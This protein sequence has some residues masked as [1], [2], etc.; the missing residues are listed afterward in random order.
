MPPPMIKSTRLAAD[1]GS[2]AGALQLVTDADGDPIAAWS[3][4]QVTVD[5]Q[6][7]TPAQAG[8]TLTS[9][10]H[11]AFDPRGLALYQRLDT[12]RSASVSVTYTASDGTLTSNPATITFGVAGRDDAPVLQVAPASGLEDTAIPLDI[13]ASAIDASLLTGESVPEEVGP[14][15]AVTGATVNAGG[16]L[17]VRATR[18]GAD[19]RLAQIARLVED[20]QS[21]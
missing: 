15:D 10:G 13:R 20:A 6:E 3:I 5:G 11:Y 7:V 21:G 19:T 4:V 1:V 8:L 9:D 2:L 17:V 14:G 12:G 16:R 18:V